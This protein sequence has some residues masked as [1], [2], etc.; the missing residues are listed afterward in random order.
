MQMLEFFDCVHLKSGQV[1]S[2]T[3]CS[4]SSCL[5]TS[6]YSIDGISTD[7][8]LAPLFANSK[9]KKPVADPTSKTFIPV[10]SKGNLNRGKTDR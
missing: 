4:L 8:T 3:N 9:A 1:Y 5:G 10:M 7:V 6:Q 2:L